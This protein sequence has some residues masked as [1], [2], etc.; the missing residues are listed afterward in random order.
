MISAQIG[1]MTGPKELVKQ[2]LMRFCGVTSEA[3]QV[4]AAK[5]AV[6]NHCA[7]LD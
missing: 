5:S 4:L 3:N 6:S 1:C 2:A 7:A